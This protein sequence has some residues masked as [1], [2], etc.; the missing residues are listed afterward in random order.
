MPAKRHYKENLEMRVAKS[1]AM[2][3]VVVC[4]VLMAGVTA[5][6]WNNGPAAGTTN[7]TSADPAWPGTF[8]ISWTPEFAGPPLHLFTEPMNFHPAGGGAPQPLGG[9]DEFPVCYVSS[10]GTIHRFT[11]AHWGAIGSGKVILTYSTDV[12][13]DGVFGEAGPPAEHSEQRILP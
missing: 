7:F 6:A 9:D 12:D 13:G 4:L 11:V 10:G 8:E 3:C 5:A 2:T 1:S